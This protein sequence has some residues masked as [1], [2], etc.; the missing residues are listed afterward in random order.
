MKKSAAAS[1]AE[2]ESLAEEMD[3]RVAQRTAEQTPA[4]E[5][6]KRELAEY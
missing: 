1:P 3:R 2:H 6:P 4:S 5:K